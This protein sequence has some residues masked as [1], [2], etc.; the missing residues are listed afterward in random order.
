[1]VLFFLFVNFLQLYLCLRTEFDYSDW[2]DEGTY[3]KTYMQEQKKHFP[4]NGMPST[5]YT[6]DLQ[7]AKDLKHLGNISNKNKRSHELNKEISQKKT[8]VFLL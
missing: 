8:Y 5:L 1:M 2:V 7:Y 3:L 4:S 6:A